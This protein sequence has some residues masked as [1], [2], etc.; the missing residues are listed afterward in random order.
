MRICNDD[1]I[2]KTQLFNQFSLEDM[3]D[4]LEEFEKNA[5]YEYQYNKEIE[6]KCRNG[7]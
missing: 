6:S 4:T 1:K 2:S 5:E 7:K 3:L